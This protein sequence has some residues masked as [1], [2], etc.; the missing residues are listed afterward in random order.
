MNQPMN[1]HTNPQDAAPLPAVPSALLDGWRRVFVNR[2]Q[3]YAVQQP[4]GTYRWR[5]E[6]CEL[7]VLAG[8]LG[9]APTL[10]LASTDARGWCK[11]ACLDADAA[12][13]LP[14]LVAL[15]RW[16]AADGLPGVLEASRRGGHPLLLFDEART[17]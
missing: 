7:D 1:Q 17:A 9:G 15:A 4:D 6:P 11:W 3:P 5:Q 14:Q 16:L 8:H 13:A 2:S 12:D 10:A